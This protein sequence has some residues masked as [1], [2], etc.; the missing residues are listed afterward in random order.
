MDTLNN[1]FQDESQDKI[2]FNKISGPI[3]YRYFNIEG[4]KL[5]I[6]GD[7]HN[8]D[9]LC[10]ECEN[11]CMKIQDLIKYVA[12]EAVLSKEYI[13]VFL[14]IPYQFD[15]KWERKDRPTVIYDIYDKF[16]ECFRYRKD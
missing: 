10:T 4:H 8:K 16:E 11:G 7:K 9:T 5:H 1:K 6:F 3:N 15:E 14:E 13:D 12:D 2:R